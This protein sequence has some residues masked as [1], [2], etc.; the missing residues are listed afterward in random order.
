MM[1]FSKSIQIKKLKAECI[2]TRFRYC[3]S[4]IPQKWDNFLLHSMTNSEPKDQLDLGIKYTTSF[5]ATA[6]NNI[7]HTNK[8]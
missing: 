5:K 1:H 8:I 6:L 7:P 2:N 4:L 3:I